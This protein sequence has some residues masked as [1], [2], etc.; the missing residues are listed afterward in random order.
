MNNTAP[1]V[2][3]VIPAYNAER[4]IAQT[5]ASALAQTITDIEVIVVDDGSEDDTVGVA[6]SIGDPRVRVARQRN[7]GSAAARN[8]GINQANGEWVA[9]L[10][11]DDLWVPHKLERQLELLAANPGSS[12]AQGSA[13]IIDDELAVLDVRRSVPTENLLMAFLRFR[14]LPAASSS[15]IVRRSILGNSV[16]FDPGLVILEDW[17]FSLK[18]ARHANPIT[19]EEPLSMYR[20]HRGNRS[21]NLSIHI[22]PGF[23][24][25]G[26][27]F[28]DPDLP[29]EIREHEQEVYARFY[30]MLC[31]GALRCREW[32]SCC[33]WGLRAVRTDPHVLWYIV[34]FPIRRLQR[35]ASARPAQSR[36]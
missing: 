7:T 33:Y 15:W 25:L 2:S 21:R 20:Q 10:D 9:F 36:S 11:A 18:L 19:I 24:V 27:I 6:K 12:A 23:R 31:G 34:S 4:T 1:L 13:Y 14:N 35:R 29:P 22:E 17:D 32:Q 30:T 8:K 5:I 16:M 28:A 26:R 3:V